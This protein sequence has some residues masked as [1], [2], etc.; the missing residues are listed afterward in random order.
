MDFFPYKVTEILNGV[1]TVVLVWMFIFLLLHLKLTYSFLRK[2]YGGPGGIRRTLGAMYH[3]NKPEI[4]LGTIVAF[5]T[6]R[7]FFLWYLRFADN[8]GYEIFLLS[9]YGSSLLILSTAGLIIGVSCWIRVI[10]PYHGMEAFWIWSTMIGTSLLF[11]LGMAFL[12]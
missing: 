11:G 3:D 5:F 2:K 4:A 6:V 9:G 10:S 12:L 1:L 7:T 8:H